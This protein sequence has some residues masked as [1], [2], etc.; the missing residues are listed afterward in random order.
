MVQ[1]SDNTDGNLSVSWPVQIISTRHYR[2]PV[3]LCARVSN[4]TSSPDGQVELCFDT[5]TKGSVWLRTE[6]SSDYYVLES[7]EFRGFCLAHE[8]GRLCLKRK[9]LAERDNRVSVL[10]WYDG[11]RHRRSTTD[12]TIYGRVSDMPG[13]SY[14]RLHTNNIMRVGV[15]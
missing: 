3:Y 14:N 2:M 4:G 10:P 13:Y 9:D 7:E 11:S 15:V 5:S 8:D 1:G 6:I 12:I